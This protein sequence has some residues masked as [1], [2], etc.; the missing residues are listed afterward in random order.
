MRVLV[1]PQEFK[2]SLSADEAAAA[3]ARGIRRERPEWEVDVLPLADGGPGFLDAIRRSVTSDVVGSVVHDAL[4]RKV[5]ARS[6]RLRGQATAVIE[7]AQAN[8]LLHVA[9][10]ER[11]ALAADSFGVGE[12]IAGALDG[13]TKRIVVGVGGSATTDGGAG[14]ARAL[15]ARFFDADGDELPP[16]GGPLARLSRM[17]WQ[18]PA[19]LDGVEVV[20]ACDVRNPLTGPQGAAAVYG[21]QKGATPDQVQRLD[22]ALDRFAAVVRDSLGV[23]LADMPGA[24]A[25]GG[26]AAGLVAFL[27][28][29]VESGFEIVADVTGFD[30]RLASA[31]VVVTGEGSYDG[32]S[33]EGKTTGQVMARAAAAGKPGVVLAGRSSVS[34]VRTLLDLEPDEETAMARAAVLLEELAARWAAE[35]AA[36]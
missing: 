10:A 32:Q 8:G 6:L 3:I 33:G 35:T 17:T 21:P 26:L 5:V 24:G 4:G 34:H 15:G 13:R 16:G 30:A 2:G 19:A 20:V 11:D 12:L 14:M 1:A 31:D 29:R 27:G 18:R 22:Q 25:A 9:P 7:A 23:D 36:T 28:A